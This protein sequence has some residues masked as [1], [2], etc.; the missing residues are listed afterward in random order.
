MILI[1]SEPLL[2]KPEQDT[3]GMALVASIL[4]HN[5][6]DPAAAK[7]FAVESAIRLQLMML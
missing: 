7:A 5:M 1:V 4:Q 6:S 3:T 2:Y